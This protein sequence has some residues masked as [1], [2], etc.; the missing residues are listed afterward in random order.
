VSNDLAALYLKLF[1]L[2]FT[3]VSCSQSTGCLENEQMLKVPL[4]RIPALSSLAAVSA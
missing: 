1:K 3:S 2:V 4:S